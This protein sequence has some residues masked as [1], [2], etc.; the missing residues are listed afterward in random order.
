MGETE[1]SSLGSDNT[2]S[3]F[4]RTVFQKIHAPGMANME[5]HLW[6]MDNIETDI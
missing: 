4:Q 1:T 5:P 2:E 6:E 3:N